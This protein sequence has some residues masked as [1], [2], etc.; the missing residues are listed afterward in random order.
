MEKLLRKKEHDE[1]GKKRE[2][3]SEGERRAFSAK[4]IEPISFPFELYS[5]NKKS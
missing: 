5:A 2:P 3:R 1:S 4:K